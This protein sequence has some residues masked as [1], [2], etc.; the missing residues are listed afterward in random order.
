MIPK[1]RFQFPH[2]INE[3]VETPIISLQVK[4]TQ[5]EPMEGI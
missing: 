3:V 4:K 2:S 1:E 5:D